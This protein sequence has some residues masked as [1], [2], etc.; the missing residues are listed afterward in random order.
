MI[1]KKLA[2]INISDTVF[3]FPIVFSLCLK[4]IVPLNYCIALI[5]NNHQ[6]NQ[7]TI[8]TEICKQVNQHSVSTLYYFF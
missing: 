4:Y 7:H 6:T 2:L 1:N 8:K 5:I 3:S